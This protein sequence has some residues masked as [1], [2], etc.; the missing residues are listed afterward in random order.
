MC[1]C[2]YIKWLILTKKH[3]KKNDIEAI[4]DD[5][6]TLWLDEK[7]IERKLG[8]K[9]LQ[10]IIN[11]YDKMYKNHRHELVNN[12]KKQPT[13]RFLRS[14]LEDFYIVIWIVQQMNQAISKEI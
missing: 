6:N 11:K 8:H 4:V 13:R 12:P 7:H 9:N 2:V 14:D 1:V 5:I 10:F 3:M